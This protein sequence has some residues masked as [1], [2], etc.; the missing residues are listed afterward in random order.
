MKCGTFRDEHQIRLD[1][2]HSLFILPISFILLYIS[3]D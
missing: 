2:G 3:L 1:I